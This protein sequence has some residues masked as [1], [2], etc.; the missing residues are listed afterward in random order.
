MTRKEW[1]KERQGKCP[2][3]LG[4]GGLEFD[5]QKKQKHKGKHV[6]YWK[7]VTI[8]WETTDAER[9]RKS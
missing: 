6:D 3:S 8:T 4:I 2:A 5:C 9:E 7:D 1:L